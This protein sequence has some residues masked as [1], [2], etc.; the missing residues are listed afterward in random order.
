MEKII[1]VIM[2]ENDEKFSIG[3]NPSPSNTFAFSS[4]I[5][6]A[7]FIHQHYKELVSFTSNRLF[8]TLSS[9]I[10]IEPQD[11]VGDMYL[12][13]LSP[14]ESWP[15]YYLRRS[16]HSVNHCLSHL[17]WCMR[18]MMINYTRQKVYKINK[19][20]IEEARWLWFD[21]I[22]QFVVTDDQ[23]KAIAKLSQRDKKILWLVM[24]WYN[25]NEIALLLG[26][27]YNSVRLKV[28]HM[29]NRLSNFI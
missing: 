27:T 20:D 1:E 12:H 4:E 14:R 11:I 22:E 6:F 17:K 9:E 18:N 2:N 21:H 10:S 23:L 3:K 29:R 26:F 28:F 25:Y 15:P 24:E 19:V 16:Y 7:N 5:E 13:Y 8:N